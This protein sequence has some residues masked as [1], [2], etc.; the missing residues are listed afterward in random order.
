MSLEGYKIVTIDDTA[1]I[2]TFLRVSLQDEGVEF[3]EA[4]TASDGLRLCKDISPDLIVLDL[5]LP[6]ADGLDVLPQIKSQGEDAPA[7]IILTVRKGRESIEKAYARGADGY[8]TK[9]FMMDD[10]METIENV[11]L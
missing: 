4:A 7:V 10:L 5:G 9:P 8:L 1:S 6:D 11:L 3:H 2:R